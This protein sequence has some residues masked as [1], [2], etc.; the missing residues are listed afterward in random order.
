MLQYKGAK[1][2]LKAPYIGAIRPDRSLLALQEVRGSHEQ[3][4]RFVHLV[5]PGAQ[6]T[7]S[8]MFGP[9]GARRGGVATLPPGVKW[10]LASQADV[11]VLG[12]VLRLRIVLD[13]FAFVH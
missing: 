11:L 2:S 7:S 3:L 4:L 10:S 12:R 5:S 13:N 1:A 6:V 9:A 8:F